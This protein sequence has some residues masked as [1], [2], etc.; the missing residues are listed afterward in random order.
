MSLNFKC[1]AFNHSGGRHARAKKQ[2]SPPG[3]PEGFISF[4]SKEPQGNHERPINQQ[5]V[6]PTIDCNRLRL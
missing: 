1:G 4:A 2:A 3:L 5:L 6:D